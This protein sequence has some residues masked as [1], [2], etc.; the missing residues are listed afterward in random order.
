VLD[1]VDHLKVRESPI[2]QQFQ[3]SFIPMVTPNLNVYS[4]LFRTKDDRAAAAINAA[5]ANLNGSK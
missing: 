5:I 1:R 2:T 3:P 4:H